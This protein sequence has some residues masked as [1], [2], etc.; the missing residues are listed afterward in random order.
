V[1]RFYFHVFDDIV[2]MDEAGQ[3]ADDLAA[4]RAIALDGARELVCEQ[5]HCGYLNLENYVVVADEQGRELCRIEFRDAFRILSNPSVDDGK[6]R[7]GQ[8]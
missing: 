7:T 8:P 3:V 1:P 5:V 6:S 4:A 2:S